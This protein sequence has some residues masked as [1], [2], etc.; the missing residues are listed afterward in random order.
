MY[1]LYLIIF[2]V[3][4][5]VPDIFKQDNFVLPHEQMEELTIFVLGMMGFLFFIMK[6]RQLAVQRKEKEREQRRLQ[7]TAK[8]LVESYSYIGEVN[9]KMDLLMQI[10]L[11]LSERSTMNKTQEKEI[12]QSIIDSTNFLLKAECSTLRFVNVKTGRIV[13][14]IVFDEKC[15]PLEEGIDFFKMGENIHIKHVRDYIVFCSQKTI[16]DVRSFL[17][18]K[19]PDEFQSRDNNNQEIIKYLVSQAL[20]LYSYLAKSSVHQQEQDKQ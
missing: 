9:R 4:V 16:N 13:K 1:W 12:Y 7:Q 2:T 5:M 3:A 10:G 19:A 14:D 18:A 8:D 15:R 6:E 20:F 11:G 17:I